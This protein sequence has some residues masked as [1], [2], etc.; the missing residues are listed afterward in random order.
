MFKGYFQN[1]DSKYDDLD[2]LSRQDWDSKYLAD[3]SFVL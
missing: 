1:S 2:G 3:M